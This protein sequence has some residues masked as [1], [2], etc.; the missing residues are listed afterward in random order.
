M[1]GWGEMIE[2]DLQIIVSPLM[3]MCDVGLSVGSTVH[4]TGSADQGFRKL[5]PLVQDKPHLVGQNKL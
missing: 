3:S 1:R 5:L 4:R 2:G